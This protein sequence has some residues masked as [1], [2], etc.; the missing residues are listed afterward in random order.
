MSRNHGQWSPDA[1]AAWQ[2]AQSAA[3]RATTFWVLG[4]VAMAGGGLL[5]WLGVREERMQVQPAPLPGGGGVIVS[6]RFK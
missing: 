3:D 1:Q 4:G 2:N 6:G 5:Y